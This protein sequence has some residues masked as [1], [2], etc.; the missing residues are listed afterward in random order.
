IGG[1]TPSLF[2][3]KSYALL[4]ENLQKIIPWDKNIEIT[5]EANPGTVDNYRFTEYRQVGINR[6]SIG[7]QSFQDRFLK[8]CGRIHDAK[9]AHEAIEKAYLAGFENLNIDLMYGLPH[10]N[11]EDALF[12]LQ[13]AINAAPKHISWY[14]L[15]IEPNTLFYKKPPSQPKEDIF[16]EIEV[17]GR[18]LLQEKGWLRYEVSAYCQDNAYCQHNLNYWQYGDYYGIG[19]GAHSKLTSPSGIISRLAKH[20]MPKSYLETQNFISEIKIIDSPQDIMFE[21]MLNT[22]RL[23]QP[24]AFQ[25]FEEQTGLPFNSIEV[26]LQKAAQQGLIYLQKDFWAISAKGL[27]FNNEII[28]LFL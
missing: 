3:A 23:V 21:Y 10:Q 1:G 28:Q 7:V 14:E 12:D 2:S 15:T 11:T 8:A 27:H 5:L 13:T 17:Q 6:L 20:R 19:A 18:S 25:H 9:K 24:H 26:Y 22:C 4:F 16:I